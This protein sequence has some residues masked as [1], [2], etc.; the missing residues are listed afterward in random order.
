MIK[1]APAIIRD[2]KNYSVINHCWNN[3]LLIWDGGNQ[4]KFLL[5]TI[6]QIN[7]LGVTRDVFLKK[8][9]KIKT[10]CVILPERKKKCIIPLW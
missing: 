3:W 1:E 9:N 10:K 2:G 5:H 4:G 7:S 8:K 6:H